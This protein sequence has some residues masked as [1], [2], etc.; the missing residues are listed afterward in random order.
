MHDP[1]Q[2]HGSAVLARLVT[3]PSEA[4]TLSAS[5]P[6]KFSQ[7][8]MRDVQMI[9]H[10]IRASELH[11]SPRSAWVNTPNRASSLP[12]LIPAMTQSYDGPLM[13]TPVLFC[14]LLG[15]YRNALAAF[16]GP[17]GLSSDLAPY[18]DD[19]PKDKVRA[20]ACT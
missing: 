13:K 1:I 20:W 4:Q 5:C 12:P 15:E 14:P 8:I 18:V 2:H 7:T 19:D 16:Q 10:T 6:L 17:R 9:R 3:R 11:R